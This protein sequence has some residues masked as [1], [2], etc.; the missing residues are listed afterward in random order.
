MT[1]H[2]LLYTELAEWW[3]LVSA[4][5]EY[6]EEAAAYR[7][8]IEDAAQILV[9]DVLELGS[10][11][12]NNASH[13]K[14]HYS[15][16]L[17]DLSPAMLEVSR[18]LNPECRHQE[19]DM[20]SVRLGAQ[21]DAVFIHDAADYLVTMDEVAAA[22]R[23]ASV[24]CRP[25]GALLVAPDYVRETF[26]PGVE[27]GGTDRGERGAR[28]LDWTWDPDPDDTT[29]RSE[30][31]LVLRDGEEVAVRHDRHACGLFPEAVWL[32]AMD[33]AGFAAR[34]VGIELGPEHHGVAFAGTRRVQG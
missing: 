20:L 23:T 7:A 33:D 21:F 30:L 1:A 10:G 6:A 5:E 3:P 4:P 16:T 12:G 14:R 2:H 29:Y 22:M 34:A 26:Q 13:L 18:R 31:V 17:V 8:L 28:Y 9:R 27:T 19:G 25:G 11:G 24:H 32:E 15:L